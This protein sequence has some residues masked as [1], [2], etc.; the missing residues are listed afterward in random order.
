MNIREK[1]MYIPN[2]ADRAYLETIDNTSNPVATLSYGDLWYVAIVFP[3]MVRYI[4][5]QNVANTTAWQGYLVINKKLIGEIDYENDP[6]ASTTGAT[7]KQCFDTLAFQFN[8]LTTL[9]TSPKY[10]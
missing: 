7:I 4:F 6:L 3:R 10:I 1:N 8:D 5:V 2:E 9:A